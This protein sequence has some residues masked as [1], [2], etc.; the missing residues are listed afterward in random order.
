MSL[1]IS[2]DAAVHA[3]LIFS[4]AA[5]IASK[6]LLSW[7]AFN[8]VKASSIGAFLSSDN[9][10]PNSLSCFSVWKI[11]PSAPLILSAVSFALLSASAFASASCFI[12]SIS[13]SDKPEDASILMF[14]SFP[15]ALSFADTF[16]IPFASISKV[17]SIWGTPLGAGGISANWNLPIDLLSAAIG[18]SPC[19]TW[20]STAGWLS[21]AVEK[22]SDFLVGIVVLASINFVK[23]PP[24][25]SIPSESGVT[26]NNNT[27]VT[28]PV[29]TP[30][31]I[32]APIA[33]T[34]SGLTPFE[35]DFPKYFSTTSCIAGILVDP[36]TNITSSI[37]ELVIPASFIAFLQGVIVAWI[38]LSANCSN[39]ALVKV[40]TK[41]FGPD[42]V[43]VTYGKLIS[44]CVDEE[45]STF[46]FSAASFNLCKA[47]GSFLK[48][49]FSS[50]LNSS[51]N[52]SIITWS[53]SSPPKCVSPFVDFTSNT[54]SPK[55]R[56]EISKVP[57]PKS[58]TA[59]VLSLSDLSKP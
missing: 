22:V 31:W 47:I 52:Q 49:M 35:G 7:A 57:P 39:C 1:Y 36:P 14:C 9:F 48:S 27:S 45:S 19:N 10:S 2:S 25:V 29:K 16:K 13:S 21:A 24:I 37:S 30:P 26:S 46:A 3:V 59:I 55:S 23:T 38:N 56:I 33:T 42:A 53:K 20:M 18:L 12:F 54:P 51:A 32:A 15:V 28:S 17:T 8:S 41:C 50:F 34:S 4:I 40:L 58:N 43:A 11:I 44:V 5:S 6:S